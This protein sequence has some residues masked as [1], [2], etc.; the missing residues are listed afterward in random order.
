[1]KDIFSKIQSVLKKYGFC[2]TCKKVYQYLKSTIITKL[3]FKLYFKTKK[4]SKEYFEMLN[5]LIN[6]DIERIIIWRSS[7]GWNVPLFQRPQQIS[8]CFSKNKSLVFYEVSSAT[9]DVDTIKKQ[10]DNLYL[11]NFNN[12]LFS[13]ILMESIKMTDKPKYLQIYSTNWNM[14][15]REMTNYINNGFKILYEY[16]DDLNPLLAGTKELPINIKEKYEYIMND[17]E[18]CFVVVT[19]DEIENDVIKK[20]GSEKLVFSCNGVDYDFFH[21]INK[22]FRFDKDFNQI[23]KENKPIVGYYGALASWFDYDMIKFLAKERPNYNIVLFGIKYDDSLDKQGLENY[24][25]IYFLGSRDYNILKNYAYKFNVCTIPF[26]IN[27]ITKSTSP[28]KLF[29]YMAI[30]KPIV[31]TAMHECQKYKSVMIAKNKKEFVKLIDNAICM[32]PKKD[33]DY[34]KLLKEEALDNTWN[35]KTIKIIKLLKKY[36]KDK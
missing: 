13:K 12:P 31:T 25:N 11:V 26:L 9:D 33:K 24:K 22:N 36:E 2:G 16:I 35:A 5:Q 4:K 6:S 18:N 32:D 8:K 23:L 29:E 17:T 21:N 27:D 7:F 19:A 1:M 20:R 3:N 34:F 15:L 14:T 10:R 30:E 28:V